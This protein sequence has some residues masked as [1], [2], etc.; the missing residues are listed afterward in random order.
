MKLNTPPSFTSFY[1]SFS[2]L[3]FATMAIFAL[4]MI[5]FATQVRPEIISQEDLEKLQQEN[6]ELQQNLDEAV[7]TRG[8]E[9]VVAIDASGSMGQALNEL[10]NAI[11][12][13]GEALPL[14]S[15]DF[16][17]G[18]VVYRD[19][20]TTFPLTRI[21]AEKEDNGAS[22]KRLRNWTKN[23]KPIG[24][25]VDVYQAVDVSMSML[26]KNA[27]A[28][29]KQTF[30]LIGDMGP[31]ESWINKQ[32]GTVNMGR[33]GKEVTLEDRIVAR[34]KSWIDNSENAGVVVLYTGSSQIRGYDYNWNQKTTVPFFKR[35]A[36]LAGENGRYADET[37]KLSVYLLEGILGGHL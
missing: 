28:D 14:V 17:L 5:I 34:V 31:Y 24:S 7:K 21:R 1:E 3:I 15:P 18:V 13:I 22:F 36:E 8:L 27:N 12:F 30:M 35:I 9:L 2:D 16:K 32:K 37:R 4:L 11:L 25:P 10:K 29:T 6:E 20:V 33:G 19:K 26:T 23:L